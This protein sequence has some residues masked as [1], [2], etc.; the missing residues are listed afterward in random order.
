MNIGGPIKTRKFALLTLIVCLAT[1]DVESN[2]N[3]CKITTMSYND[4][5]RRLLNLEKDKRI[6]LGSCEERMHLQSTF[7]STKSEQLSNV[8]RANHNINESSI[9]KLVGQ[10]ALILTFK[11]DLRVER[12]RTE[13]SEQS[14]HLEF[15]K[16]Q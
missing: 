3:H 6:S 16:N 8:L 5:I 12:Q 14:R 13:S 10:L 11:H 9:Q 7:Q 2:D 4:K 1:I 15:G